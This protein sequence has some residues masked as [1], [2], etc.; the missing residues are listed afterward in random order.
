MRLHTRTLREADDLCSGSSL[1]RFPGGVGEPTGAGVI[2]AAIPARRR[3]LPLGDW[4]RGACRAA[5]ALDPS[6]DSLQL[7]PVLSREGWIRG[8]EERVEVLRLEQQIPFDF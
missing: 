1:A 6:A 3:A 4:S 5:R 2:G 7:F 8:E